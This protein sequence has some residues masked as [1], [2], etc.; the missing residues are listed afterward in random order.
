MSE[1]LDRLALESLPQVALNASEPSLAARLG[2]ALRA[3]GY[4]IVEEAAYADVILGDDA[5]SGQ[6]HIT[7]PGH[8]GEQAGLVSR[9]ASP[10]QI[11]AALRAVAA[12][13]IV[14]P[15]ERDLGFAAMTEGAGTSP[16]TPR[17]VEVLTLISEGLAN[18]EIAR[19][20]DISLHTVKFHI[21]SIFRKLGVRARAEAVARGLN[22]VQL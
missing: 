17:E 15:R 16:L 14:R 3:L 22:L 13:L 20:L 9:D 19:K 21:E 6:L 10:A 5:A 18:K 11:D 1:A 8:E 2:R 12:G 7:R 4:T